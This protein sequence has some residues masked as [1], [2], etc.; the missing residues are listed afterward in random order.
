MRDLALVTRKE[1]Y[2]IAT[3]VLLQLSCRGVGIA[4]EH[5]EKTRDENKEIV[6]KGKA[7]AS[8]QEGQCPGESLPCNGARQLFQDTELEFPGPLVSCAYPVYTGSSQI[9][10]QCLI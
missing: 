10:G 7:I 9:S 5:L 3:C 1:S 2:R 4:K 8:I 6:T